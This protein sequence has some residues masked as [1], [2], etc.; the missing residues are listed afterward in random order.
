MKKPGAVH[1]SGFCISEV[2][3]MDLFRETIENWNDWGRIFQS[4]PAFS[5]L[6]EE[7][8]RREG[9]PVHPL[10]HLTPGSNAVFR[11]GDLVVKIFAPVESGID[12]E[13]DY[14]CERA[15]M[16]HAMTCGIAVPAL[17]AAGMVEDAYAFRYLV[18]DYVPGEEGGS[19]LSRMD[20]NERVRFAEALRQMTDALHCPCPDFPAVDVWARTG[21]R[22]WNAFSPR[23]REEMHCLRGKMERSE[24]V[25]VHGDITAENI[26]ITPNGSLCLI[27]FADG[28]VTSPDY[29]L[30]PVLFD[31]LD[32]DGDAIAAYRGGDGPADFARRA[33]EGVLRHEY[34]GHFAQHICRRV[35][36]RAPEEL[37]SLERMADALAAHLFR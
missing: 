17:R 11:T 16:I 29:E 35:L 25:Y 22:G 2:K 18:M 15:G 13:T 37:D 34:G 28:R 20:G 26:L 3:K 33:M 9:L 27:D 30:P 12:M 4:I 5:A 14:A 23:V 10:T 31:L 24:A 32:F 21:I 1:A 36:D 7:I 8:L 6:A 19:A